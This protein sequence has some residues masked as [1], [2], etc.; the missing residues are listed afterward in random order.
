[1]SFLGVLLGLLIGLV[2]PGPSVAAGNPCPDDGFMKQLA[3]WVGRTAE[4]PVVITLEESLDYEDLGDDRSTVLEQLKDST[5]PVVV[6]V[7]KGART[8]QGGTALLLVFDELLIHPDA[9][10][11]RLTEHTRA[12]LKA[13]GL[14]ADDNQLCRAVS[15]GEGRSA[16]LKGSELT[17]FAADPDANSFTVTEV[18]KDGSTTPSTSA[19]A[20]GGQGEGDGDQDD[21]A[22]NA[23]DTP[24]DGGSE[25]G[26]SSATRT[27]F[28]MALLLALLLL[29]FVIVIRRSR[30]PVAVGHRAP[31]P[32]RAVGGFARM[33]PTRSAPAHAARS[34]GG[35]AGAGAGANGGGGGAGGHGGGDGDGGDEST[36]RLRVASGPRHGRQV[37]A[38]PSHAR[39][40]VVRTELHPQGY[41]EVDRVLRRAVWAEPGRPPPA[42]GGLV[43]VTDAREPDSDVLYAFPPTAARHAKGT[44]R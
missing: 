44:P 27:A 38:R 5:H 40:A 6:Q 35:S 41:V 23:V 37:G 3:C 10:I 7:P 32:G 21:K 30:G 29:A 4:G 14:C 26:Y 39:T 25:A 1:M 28:W 9:T 11:D 31:S 13:N 36:T 2:P 24:D 34:G 42:P 17:D 18:D 12:D 19:G 22:N 33:A 43:D 16:K 8:G 20:L 15:P